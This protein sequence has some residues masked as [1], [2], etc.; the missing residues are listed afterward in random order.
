MVA[1]FGIARKSGVIETKRRRY[2]IDEEA[3]DSGF[4]PY[5]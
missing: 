2:F 4:A 5:E 3:G 1:Q